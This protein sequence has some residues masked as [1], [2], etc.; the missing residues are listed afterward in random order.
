MPES[1]L[2]HR[3]A[4]NAVVTA[5]YNSIELTVARGQLVVGF[6]VLEGWIWCKNGPNEEDWGLLEN[7]RR[8]QH[9]LD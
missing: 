5:N 4:S 2:D 3:G 7:L 1:I 8:V 9:R 6:H